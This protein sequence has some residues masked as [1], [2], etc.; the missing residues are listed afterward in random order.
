MKLVR[1]ILPLLFYLVSAATDSRAEDPFD[2][3]GLDEK[4]EV[5][6]GPNIG[7]PVT[8][9]FES[10]DSWSTALGL[11]DVFKFYT[12]SLI[13]DKPEQCSRCEGNVF[14]ELVRVDAFRK[15]AS[16]NKK[17]ALEIG[18]V[19]AEHPPCN[20]A[21]RT[22]AAL[23]IIDKVQSVGGTIDYVAMD[24]PLH[25]ALR[26]DL[27]PGCRMT[28]SAV[29]GEVQQFMLRLR[30]KSPAIQIGL[31]EPYPALS[32]GQILAFLKRLKELRSS[33]AFLHLDIDPDLLAPGWQSELASLKEAVSRL[34]IP[35]GVIYGSPTAQTNSEYFSKTLIN[36][37]RYT[38]VFGVPEHLVFQSWALTDPNLPSQRQ[39][40]PHNY[41]ESRPSLA[42]LVMVGLDTL[43]TITNQTQ[44]VYRM[45][46]KKRGVHLYSLDPTLE[47]RDFSVESVEFRAFKT[48][49]GSMRLLRRCRTPYATFLSL[50]PSCEGYPT[51]GPIGFVFAAPARNTLPLFRC[52]HERE[53]IVTANPDECKAAKLGAALPMGHAIAPYGDSSKGGETNSLSV[54]R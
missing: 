15:L 6:F 38:S 36:L 45:Y 18:V 53:M 34:G 25:A 26:T 43:A 27:S 50:N 13:F 30:E 22:S 29:A 2:A 40:L 9:L 21:S 52:G 35:L 44:P 42:R 54:R 11:I 23:R 32:A 41:P 19:K 4:P 16:W 31:I 28:I 39:Y 46:S 51:D 7:S 24:E 8:G 20:S 49:S 14:S 10:P 12:G 47:A 3:A 33:P 5:W 17:T 1:H 37:T 48:G